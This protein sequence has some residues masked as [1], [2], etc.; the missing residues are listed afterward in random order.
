VTA[1]T[2]LVVSRT[3]GVLRPD[4][5]RTVARLFVPGQEM[6]LHGHSRLNPVI[7]RILAMTP[8]EMDATLA[9]TMERFAGRH[10]DLPGLLQ[11]N[12][13]LVAHRLGAATDLPL[14][15]R[16]L[17][18]AYFTHEYSVEAAALFNPSIVAHPD[19]TGVDTGETRVVLSLRGVGEGHLSS[20]EFRTGTVA[21]D[22]QVRIDEA[23]RDL[24]PAERRDATF[25]QAMFHRTLVGMGVDSEDAGFVLGSLPDPFT[26]AE[27][28][29]VLGSLRG[30]EITRA[31]AGRT[32]A[33]LRLIASC[34]YEVRFPKDSAL[35]QRV[36]MPVAPTESHGME[37][38]RFV[39]FTDD[40]GTVS[41]QATYTAF[42]GTSVAPQLLTTTDFVTFQSSQL[43]GPAA[44]NKGM[45]LFPRRIGGRFMA[46]S[47][48]DRENTSVASSADGHGWDEPTTI[49]RPRRPWELI[50]IGN[51]G[52]PIET[53]AGWLVLTHGVGPM[54]TYAIGAMLLDLDDPTRVLGELAEPLITPTE[55]E[56]DGY[57]PN[58]V[59]TC[60]ALAHGDRLVLP[61][62]CADSTIGIAVI[63]LPRL[64]NQLTA[65]TGVA[66]GANG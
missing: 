54:R 38:A 28:D 48:W 21:A 53:A 64:L 3:S 2:P 13:E 45:A 41:Y 31:S 60:G 57:V 34:N 40:D 59:Y 16:L 18:G 35:D 1:S 29:L 62:G 66:D 20:I 6:M 9:T 37:D 65:E 55:S 26:S 46:L 7:E 52:S 61:Y 12:F 36:L 11:N 4:P 32:I 47:R 50:Q 63:D 25:S 10:H 44:A 27:L 17:I 19:Q 14:T 30:Q 8:D 23:A 5:R 58:V 42:D 49:H 56:R 15:T 22:G 43:T 33:H 39:R 51:C 24:V